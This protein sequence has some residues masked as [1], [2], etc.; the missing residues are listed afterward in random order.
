MY[1]QKEQLRVLTEI[2]NNI[3][4]RNAVLAREGRPPLTLEGVQDVIKKQIGLGNQSK[5][6]KESQGSKHCK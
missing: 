5:L 1:S 6:G 4:R 2:T 3:L